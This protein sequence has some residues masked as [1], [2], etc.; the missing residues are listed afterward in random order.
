MIS[1]ILVFVDRIV[2]VSRKGTVRVIN[3]DGIFLKEFRILPRTITATKDELLLGYDYGEWSGSLYSIRIGK[4]GLAA[5]AKQLL[6][7]NIGSIDQDSKR[8]IW[9]GGGLAHLAGRGAWLYCYNGQTITTIISE[10]M[11]SE[12]INRNKRSIA[13]TLP[14]PTD[15]AGITVNS[16]DE[17]VIVASDSGLFSYTVGKPLRSLW[18]GNLYIRYQIPGVSVG[19]FPQGHC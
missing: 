3:L 16:K 10:G 13:I 8:N 2:E 18:E 19:S 7:E 1:H 17:V 12:Q 4:Q 11:Y 5:K 15:I 6:S 14:K 9:I